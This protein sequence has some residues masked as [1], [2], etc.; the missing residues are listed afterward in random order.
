[1]HQ[2]HPDYPALMIGNYIF[3]GSGMKSRLGDRIRQREGLS[4]GVGS[5]FSASVRTRSTTRPSREL[6][7]KMSAPHAEMS[8][9]G[10]IIAVSVAELANHKADFGIELA[11][12]LRLRVQELTERLEVFVPVY[13]MF[14]KADLI[15]GFVDFFEDRERSERDKVWGATLPYQVQGRID[16]AE[17]FDHHFEVFVSAREHGHAKPD[18]PIF[19]ATCER[20]GRAPAEV[21]HIGDDPLL[22]VAGARL[23]GLRSC[24]INREKQR[25]PANLPRPDLEFATL[26]GLA[27]WLDA[28]HPVT[29]TR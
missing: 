7:E 24:W 22:D 11:R 13:V 18:A 17:A 12:K 5:N 27:D 6:V 23:A 4:Y 2:D 19:H 29:E 8:T 28:R 25:W 3:G 16:A 9:A 14:T 26:A 20:L 15:A 1:M 21:L 10:V